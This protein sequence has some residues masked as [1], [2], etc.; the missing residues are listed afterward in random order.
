MKITTEYSLAFLS[1]NLSVL[2]FK[3]LSLVA[4]GGF[5]IGVAGEC[6]E[7]HFSRGGG[8]VRRPWVALIRNLAEPH[9]DCGAAVI[10]SSYLVSSASCFCQG[11]FGRED[12]DNERTKVDKGRL[13][14]QGDGK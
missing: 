9:L 5:L 14:C 13:Q 4:I 8:Y 7:Y 11:V 12:D 10:G 3:A 2:G 6:G 1:F